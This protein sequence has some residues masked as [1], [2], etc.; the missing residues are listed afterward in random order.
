MGDDSGD[1]GER[2]RAVREERRLSQTELAR[3][4]LSPSYLS[5]IESGKRTPSDSVLLRLAE[6]LDVSAHFLRHG[7]AAPEERVPELDLEHARHALVTGDLPEADRRARAVV[8]A[9]GAPRRLHDEA[10][11]VLTRAREQAGDL[12]GAFALI[13][14]LHQRALTGDASA[15]VAQTGVLLLQ[16]LAQAGDMAQAVDV[17][18]VAVAASER[19]G[20]AGTDE[21][22]RLSAALVGVHVER[23]DLLYARHLAEELLAAAEGT[24]SRAGQAGLHWNAAVAAEQSGHPDRALHHARLAVA[25]A[26]EGP[27][28]HD[29]SRL[30]VTL[31]SLLLGAEPPQADEAVRRLTAVRVQVQ[32]PGNEAD[33][34]A[35]YRVRARAHLQAGEHQ[36]ALEAASAALATLVDEPS[37]EACLARTVMGDVLAAAGEHDS[38]ETELRRAADMLSMLPP[39]RQSAQ[40]WRDLGDRFMHLGR[41]AD[42]LQAFQQAFDLMGVRSNPGVRAAPG[43]GPTGVVATQ[44]RPAVPA[45]GGHAPG[46][47]ATVPH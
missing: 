1:L 31:C 14:P 46:R 6:R 15:S 13:R 44:S 23:G 4:D 29:R 47:Q 26:S 38:A 34:A 8:A 16:V 28:S 27:D 45:A 7:S 43:A 12:D 33:L 32:Q 42:A 3:D 35:W 9:R 18:A 17:G 36:A 19:M 37:L 41:T 21:H 2:M 22:L 40:V 39:S 24:D 20:A 11:L 25:F 30:T 10:T 5:L